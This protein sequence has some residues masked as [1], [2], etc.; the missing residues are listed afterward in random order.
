[1]I[2]TI[3][4]VIFQRYK[5]LNE[6]KHAI[7]NYIINY[8]NPTRPHMYNGGLSTNESEGRYE[9]SYKTVANIT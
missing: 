2:N 5:D 1:M 4:N 9:L 7:I 6:A 3:N 8:Y